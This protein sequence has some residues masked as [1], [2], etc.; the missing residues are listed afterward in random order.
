MRNTRS[1]FGQ[2]ISNL[3]LPN[4]WAFDES[5]ESSRVSWTFISSI[6]ETKAVEDK[7]ENENNLNSSNK[8]EKEASEG[9]QKQK[10]KKGSE[11]NSNEK[12]SQDDQTPKEQ[13]RT[14]KLF[15]KLWLT[16][17]WLQ[18][19]WRLYEKMKKTGL[20]VSYDTILRGI[21]KPS[22]LRLLEKQK[23]FLTNIEEK[24]TETPES[25]TEPQKVN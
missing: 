9:S 17:F 5:F 25:Q 16:K 23:K 18:E 24:P 21:L 8:T 19:C 11:P 3:Y 12:K 20:N 2:E 13:V 10:P 4:K 7:K 22:E 14:W 15:A 6:D 1:L